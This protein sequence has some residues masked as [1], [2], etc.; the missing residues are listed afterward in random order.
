MLGNDDVIVFIIGKPLEQFELECDFGKLY[1]ANNGVFILASSKGLS[2]KIPL[3]TG[4]PIICKH[5]S[6]TFNIFE[7]KDMIEYRDNKIT[8]EKKKMAQKITEARKEKKDHPHSP[9]Q[10]TFQGLKD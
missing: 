4:I 5:Y 9:L 10:K 7:L 2:I 6:K 1:F 8:E 3:N